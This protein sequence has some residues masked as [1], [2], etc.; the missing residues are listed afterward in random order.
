MQSKFTEVGSG[1]LFRNE[2]ATERQPPYSGSIEIR[3]QKLRIAAWV[4]EKE[5]KRYFSLK[6]SEVQQAEPGP[7]SEGR[8]PLSDQ[9]IP[10]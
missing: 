7:Q 2:E 8:P 4:N 6:I 9:E 10:F 5:G 3:G 1:A